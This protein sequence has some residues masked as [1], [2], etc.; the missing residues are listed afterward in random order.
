MEVYSRQDLEQ[1]KL[2]LF[3]FLISFLIFFNFI[4]YLFYDDNILRREAN[5]SVGPM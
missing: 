3:F 1:L 4:D 2:F 5:S